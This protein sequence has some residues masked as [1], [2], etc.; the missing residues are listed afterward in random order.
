VHW[1]GTVTSLTWSALVPVL[2]GWL[3]ALAVCC[4][5]HADASPARLPALPP[6][7]VFMGACVVM[8]GSLVLWP[9]AADTQ[10]AAGTVFVLVS[11]AWLTARA[12]NRGSRQQAEAALALTALGLVVLALRI[13]LLADELDA[14]MP[15]TLVAVA[16][17]QL[18]AGATLTGALTA[19]GARD[20]HTA[21]R[22]G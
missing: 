11:V 13:A 1:S 7:L 4:G 2:C 20:L 19:V 8:G 22:T 12:L 9:R 10:W 21:L 15:A 6:G 17:A 3:I 14:H 16:W 18:A 5:F